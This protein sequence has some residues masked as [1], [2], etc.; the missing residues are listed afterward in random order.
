MNLGGVD[1]IDSSG[2]DE[3]L[4]THASAKAKGGVVKLANLSKGVDDLLV[5]TK[6]D[7]VFDCFDSEDDAVNSI[8]A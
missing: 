6:L 5:L 8:G 3:L 4:R 7:L 2:L 1:G